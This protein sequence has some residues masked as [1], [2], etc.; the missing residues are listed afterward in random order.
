MLL[1]MELDEEWEIWVVFQRLGKLFKKKE[2]GKALSPES[3][4]YVLSG[5]L[6]TVYLGKKMLKTKSWWV[7][8]TRDIDCGLQ[9]RCILSANGGI[10]E[11]ELLC[12]L[13]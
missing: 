8:D 5:E 10:P 6:S 12:D 2:K 1:V 9:K 11:P 7:L 3:L 13:A 4:R